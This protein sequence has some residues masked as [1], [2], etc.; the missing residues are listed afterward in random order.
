MLNSVL[1]MH[2]L[3]FLELVNKLELGMGGLLF[4]LL[5]CI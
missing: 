3:T 2:D 4:E 5:S 1:L